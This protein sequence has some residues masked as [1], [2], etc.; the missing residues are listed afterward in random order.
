MK[1]PDHEYRNMLSYTLQELI[2]FLQHLDS[3]KRSKKD[4]IEMH[5][6]EQVDELRARSNLDFGWRKFG[7]I[8]NN[9][10]QE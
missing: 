7:S 9:W 10:R 5:T 3:V 8:T 6:P 2:P 1:S 4:E